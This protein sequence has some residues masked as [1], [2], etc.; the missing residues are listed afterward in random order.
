[1][2]YR[3]SSILLLVLLFTPLFVHGQ[4]PGTFR[5]LI[6]VFVDIFDVIVPVIFALAFLAFIW[7]IAQYLLFPGSEEKKR[8][9]RQIIIWGIVVF[10]IMVSIWGIVN[11]LSSSIFFGGDRGENTDNN[12]GFPDVLSI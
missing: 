7:G 1:M 5:E 9:G 11:L 4:S 6:N 8:T 12:S 3:V 2:I 10:F